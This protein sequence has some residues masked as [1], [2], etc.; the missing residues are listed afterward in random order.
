MKN[1]K[2]ILVCP[3]D[4]GLGHA[5]RMVAVIEILIEKGANVIIG[6]DNGPLEFLRQRFGNCD[7]VKFSGFVPKYPRGN[8]MALKM[9]LQFPEMKRQAKKSNEFLQKIIREKKIDIVISDNRYE[10]YS[11]K[12]YSVLV[13]HQVNIHTVGLQKLFAPFIKAQLNNYIK[14]YD[15]LWIPDFEKPP[16]LSGS[17]SHNT[18]IPIDNYA[19][20]GPLSRFKERETAKSQKKYDVMAILSG[21][22][23]QR[24]IF[25]KI[26][27]R[28]FLETNLKVIFLLG[29]PGN[30]NSE[31]LDN[32]EKISHLSDA[33]FAQTLMSSDL[34]IS[35]PGYST[36]MD[37]AV[38]GKNAVFVPTPGQ[39]EQEY[40]AKTLERQGN[41]YFQKQ[42]EIDINSAIQKSKEYHGIKLNNDYEVLNARINYL[43]RDSKTVH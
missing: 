12:V 19:F 26:I 25:E 21:P 16:W 11:S 14:K 33:E 17:L 15:E 39:T 35:R 7:F 4:W 40:L 24:S 43:I 13:T 34:I 1:Q 2:N 29:K 9:A 27:E 30:Q 42:G 5:S 31:T 8:A 38:F 18:R 3:L 32:I 20:I 10:L 36:I 41:Y 37:L 6:A 22:E 23:P 28:Q